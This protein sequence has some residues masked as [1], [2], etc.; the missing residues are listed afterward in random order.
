MIASRH[1][2]GHDVDY[3]LEAAAV[4]ALHE[5]HELVETAVGVDGQV[6]V[7]IV[8]VAHGIGRTG[9]SL[10]HV[11]VVGR[12]AVGRIVGGAGVMRHA[13]EPHVGDAERVEAVEHH[14]GDVGELAHAV[15]RGRAPWAGRGASTV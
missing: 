11:G 4:G 8:V 1:V 7:H 13:G 15:L 14:R 6:G 10:D 2:V 12:D 5:G 3:H 9:A